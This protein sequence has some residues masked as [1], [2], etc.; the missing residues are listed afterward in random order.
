MHRGYEKRHE[1]EVNQ[2]RHIMAYI[3]M[4]GGMGASEV[5][6]PKDVWPLPMD[7]ENEKRMITSVKQA[8]AMLK[9]FRECLS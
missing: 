4:F 3:R 7:S 5:T 8:M 9:E 1:R 2:T 6:L